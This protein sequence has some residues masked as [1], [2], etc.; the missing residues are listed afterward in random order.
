MAKITT[1]FIR[2]CPTKYSVQKQDLFSN[3]FCKAEIRQSSVRYLFFEKDPKSGYGKSKVSAKEI[4]R[5]SLKQIREEIQVWKSEVGEA[6]DGD[7]L[8]K[9]MPGMFVT[10]HM[11]LYD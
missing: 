3:I 7:F 11:D 1:L 5:N 2:C 9:G 8:L 6:W 4:I 10:I